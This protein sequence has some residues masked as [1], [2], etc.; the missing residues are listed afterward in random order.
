[1]IHLE[2]VINIH[3]FLINKF[4]G[5]HGIRDERLLKSALARPFQ[6]FDKVDLY[7]SH[8]E[9]AAALIESIISNHPFVD[10]N[11]RIGYVLM[12][13]Y[14]L[15]NGLDLNASIDEKYKFVISIASGEFQFDEILEWIN[16]HIESIDPNRP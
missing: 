10:G 6:T 4:G 8:T 13:L 16:N 12:R 7:K 9:K 2:D 14:L 15:E 11:K 1:M 3:E 5:F